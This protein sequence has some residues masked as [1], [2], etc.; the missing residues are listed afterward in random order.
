QLLGQVEALRC[1]RDRRPAHHAA[2]RDQRLAA[3]HLRLV[4]LVV[5]LHPLGVDDEPAQ[6]GPPPL[7]DPLPA[8]TTAPP[9]PLAAPPPPPPGRGG[10]G[11]ARRR[12]APRRGGAGGPAGLAP[13]CGG[14][15]GPAGGARGCSGTR[16]PAGL[17]CCGGGDTGRDAGT[18][19]AGT[20]PAGVKP[21]DAE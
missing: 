4:V 17:A 21:A 12:R 7:V 14:P 19:P 9:R 2:E 20:E 13:C 1:E 5:P 18:E 6:V 11:R 10:G 16:E 3:V 15:R 8:P